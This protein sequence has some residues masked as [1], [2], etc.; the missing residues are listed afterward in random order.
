MRNNTESRELQYEL[1][2]RAVKLGWAAERVRVI[3]ADLGVSAD[4]VAIADRDG[5][6][7]LA[8]EVALGK[9]GL[10]LGTEVSR[11]ARDNSAWYQLL[12]VCALTGT[13]IADQD[14]IYDPADYSDRLLLGLKGTISEAE[15]HLIKG[16]LTAGIRHKAA[17]GELRIPLPA[18]YD[19]AP[20]GSDRDER[21]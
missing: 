7:E 19:H 6:R 11:L 10:I 13:L 12:D 20:D 9:V 15:L 18:G 17:K 14:G 16:R 21:R 2:E 5:F 4:S 1:V 8:G 3:D